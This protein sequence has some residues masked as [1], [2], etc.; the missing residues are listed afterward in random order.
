MGK[1]LDGTF[2]VA[3]SIYR[4]KLSMREASREIGISHAT[5]CRIETGHKPD[6]DSFARV[7]SWMK[8]CPSKF[9]R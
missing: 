4:G 8:I 5:M 2:S 9:F 3:V 6:I 1:F 7:C